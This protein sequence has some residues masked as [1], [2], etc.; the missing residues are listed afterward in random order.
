VPL[1]AGVPIVMFWNKITAS[2]VPRISGGWSGNASCSTRRHRRKLRKA[3][4]CFGLRLVF[5]EPDWLGVPRH[6]F[7]AVFDAVI[8][9]AGLLEDLPGLPA[10]V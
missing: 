5:L 9:G 7:S 8:A 4:G 2:I 10:G 1:A 6:V 3:P